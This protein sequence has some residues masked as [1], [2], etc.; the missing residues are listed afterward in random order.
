MPRVGHVIFG[1]DNFGRGQ[2]EEYSRLS[3]IKVDPSPEIDIVVKTKDR[4]TTKDLT[5][6]IKWYGG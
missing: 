1:E 4:K 2:A 3:G 5:D 6:L